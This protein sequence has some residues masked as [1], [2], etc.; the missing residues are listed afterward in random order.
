MKSIEKLQEEVGKL[1]FDDTKKIK[2]VIEEL[3]RIAKSKN[4]NEANLRV[5]SN[6]LLE[7]G[8]LKES[9]FWRLV[10]VLKQNHMID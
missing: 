2:F 9:F 4:I 1:H 8:T 10:K 5:L 6:C 7:L 3:Q